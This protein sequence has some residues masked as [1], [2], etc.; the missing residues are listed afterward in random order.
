MSDEQENTAPET[1]EVEESAVAETPAEADA[2]D[3]A[4]DGE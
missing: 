4:E 3:S 2:D 1:V